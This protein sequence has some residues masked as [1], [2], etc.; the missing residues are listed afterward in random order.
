MRAQVE[1]A[2][3]RRSA[4]STRSCSSAGRRGGSHVRGRRARPLLRPDRPSTGATRSTSGGAGCTRTTSRSS[5]TG[6]RLLRGPSTPPRRCPAG[7]PLAAPFPRRGPHAARLRRRAARRLEFAVRRGRLDLLLE[8]LE[9]SRDERMRDIVATIQGDQYGL[10]T[11][12][13]AGVLVIQGGP[14][15][16]K[17]AVGLHRASWLLYTYRAP[18]SR[19]GV[20]VVGPNPTSWSTSRTSCRCSARSGSTSAPIGDL[21]ERLDV[22]VTRSTPRERR[23]K[24]RSRQWRKGSR[25]AVRALPSPPERARRRC[26]TAPTPRPDPARARELVDEA[27]Q[28]HRLGSPRRASGCRTSSL[29]RV[30]RQ[31]G[32]KLGGRRIRVVRGAARARCAR[33]ATRSASIARWP[34]VPEK[35]SSR[36]RRRLTR[37]PA[38]LERCRPRRSSTSRRAPRAARRAPTG[39]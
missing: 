29:R 28:A 19:T 2:A 12:E 18:A 37:R 32:E 5:S 7:C 11:R 36:A 38:R 17:T 31:Y 33:A 21:G 30:Y 39:T 10:I 34:R 23:R 27:S 26:S 15:T 35:L 14:G 8:E 4:R 9:R 13:P 16:G 1:A 22:E 24:G 6:R 25:D 3:A 20:L